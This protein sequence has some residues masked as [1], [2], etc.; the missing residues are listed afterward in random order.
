MLSS[1]CRTTPFNR[2]NSGHH[3]V[4]E[5]HP[6]PLTQL[7]VVVAAIFT[8]YCEFFVSEVPRGSTPFMHFSLGRLRNP[9]KGDK[10]SVVCGSPT[11]SARGLP[12]EDEAVECLSSILIAGE[13][14]GVT[15]VPSLPSGTGT[16]LPI[17]PPHTGK[18]K[19]TRLRNMQ[20][21]FSGLKPQNGCCRSSQQ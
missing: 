6:L 8:L 18:N 7:A 3:V 17:H 1:P 11:R 15:L 21:S 12:I 14:G 10:S 20:A 9:S 16:G 2:C 5:C 13:G 19:K 4:A